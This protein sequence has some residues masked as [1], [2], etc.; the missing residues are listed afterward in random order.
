MNAVSVSG[1]AKAFGATPVLD[2]LELEVPA[3]SFVAV[4]GASGC[5]KSTLLRVLAGFERADRGCVRI[6]EVVADD[7]VR[8]L[9]AS[10]RR[11][12]HVPQEGALFPHLDV[13]ANIAFGL[14]RGERRGGARVAELI[15]SLGLAGLERR[16]PH[17]LS[18]GQQQRVALARALAPRPTVVLLDEPFS[19]L[20]PDLRDRTRTDIRAAL[21]ELGTTTILVTHDQDEALSLADHV[22]LLRD[23]RIAQAGTPQELYRTPADV[24]TARFLGDA[25]LLPT[26]DGG[27]MLVRPEDLRLS[28]PEDG[29]W[30]TAVVTSVE[31]FGH[32]ARVQLR[33]EDP[34][35]APALIARTTG[36]D[37]PDVGQRV[38]LALPP[39]AHLVPHSGTRG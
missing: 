38:S 17:E 21:G 34:P 36:G 20:D 10:R 19:A 4:L 6:G 18:G 31:Y 26:T 33:C 9:P 8:R 14:P 2:G 11:V 25:N 29:A 13:R 37:T 5:G 27:L 23:G 7:G 28:P 15:A 1:L 30:R 12:G 39:A 22:A 35:D 24:D 16:R 3:G 32:D